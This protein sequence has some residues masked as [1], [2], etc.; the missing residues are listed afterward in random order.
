MRSSRDLTVKIIRMSPSLALMLVVV[1]N[2]APGTRDAAV[3][4]LDVVVVVVDNDSCHDVRR[5][6]RGVVGGPSVAGRRVRLVARDRVKTARVRL[7]RHRRRRRVVVALQPTVTCS[8]PTGPRAGS[9]A[10]S[11]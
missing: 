5:L 3:S 10:V 4:R 8:Q 2:L 11:K 7:D 6:D 9:G 1:A